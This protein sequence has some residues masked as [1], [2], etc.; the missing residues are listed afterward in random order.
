MSGGGAAAAAAAAGEGPYSEAKTSVWWDI[1]NCQVPRACDP[2]LIAQ[3]ISSALAALGYRGPVS[4]SAYG[5]TSNISPAAQHA[6]SSTGI[7][8]NHVPAGIKDASDKKILVDMLFW[9]IDNPPPANYLL[10]SGDRDFCNALHKLRMR[11]YNIL[12][13]QPPNVSQVLVTAAKSVWL[14]RS[15]LAGGPPLTEL[16]YVSTVSNANASEVSSSKTTIPE[17]GQTNQTI[18][19]SALALNLDNQRRSGNGKIDNHQRGKQVWKTAH[20]YQKDMNTPRTTSTEL[21]TQPSGSQEGL[22]DGVSESNIQKQSSADLSNQVSTSMGS[23]SRAQE[24]ANS[25]CTVKNPLF[26]ESLPKPSKSPAKSGYSHEN[27]EAL[28]K[29]APHKF[30]GA[31]K[32]NTARP[33]FPQPDNRYPMNNGY[34]NPNYQQTQTQPLRP[35]DLLASQP[36]TAKGSLHLSNSHKSNPHPPTSRP[37]GPP[38]SSQQPRAINPPFTSAGNPP[39]RPTFHQHIPPFQSYPEPYNNYPPGPANVLHNMQPPYYD[40]SHRPPITPPMPG[41]VH[42][43]GF[44]GRPEPS[45]DVQGL[46]GNILQALNILRN[47]KMAPTEA[48]IA[49]CIHFGEMNIPHFNVK[50]ALDYSIQHQVVV[51][52]KLGGNLPFFVGKNDSLWKCVNVMDST[53]KHP[54]ETWDAVSRFLSSSKGHSMILASQC[55]YQAAT[56]LRKKCL[57]HLVLGEILQILHAAISVKRWIIPHSSGWQPLTLHVEVMDLKAESSSNSTK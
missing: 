23:S 19:A 22:F 37:N 55:M 21:Q 54:K 29:E 26:P 48:N 20:K 8:L 41:N 43:P 16:P 10:I 14:W 56:I 5:D 3:N 44:W 45:S 52:H 42:N 15:L 57:K 51:M 30:F 40:Y 35:S 17:P 12:L 24:N 36:N 53:V 31:N 46:T 28:P 34:K 2:H 33:S 27:E 38:L 18:N 11:R 7:A 6:L 25:N 39:N 32:S 49:D 50:M 13:A 47:D 9:A 4:I 1:E